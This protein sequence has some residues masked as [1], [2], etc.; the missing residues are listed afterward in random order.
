MEAQA[1]RSAHSPCTLASCQ[2]PLLASEAGFV[3]LRW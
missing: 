2:M 1:L 3:L